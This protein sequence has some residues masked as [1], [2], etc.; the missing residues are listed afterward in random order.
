MIEVEKEKKKLK[1]FL[2]KKR[3]QKGEFMFIN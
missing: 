1:F 3:S 2:I